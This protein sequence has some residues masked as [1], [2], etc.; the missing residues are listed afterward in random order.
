MSLKVSP[1]LGG[2]FL[3]TGKNQD[4]KKSMGSQGKGMVIKP[5]EK[6]PHGKIDN[7]MHSE[8]D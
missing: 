4:K 6:A 5:L 8:I 2:N 7:V 1:F 3:D